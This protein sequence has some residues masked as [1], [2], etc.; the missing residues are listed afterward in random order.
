M[1]PNENRSLE[2]I[3]ESAIVVSWAD[4]MRGAQT[5]LIHIEYGF[6]TGGTLDYLKFWSSLTRG[7]WLLACEYWM[8]ASTFHCI[9]VHFDN[10]YQ[11]E[12]LAH[13]L[14]AV[15]QHQNAFTLPA[16]L[17]RQ[18]LLQIP[19]PTPE[20]RTAATASVNE[21]FDRLGPALAEPVLA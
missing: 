6:A 4:L 5:G 8:S 10:G 1:K 11:S 14:D 15:M 16:D 12:G 7:H 21:A 19:T 18:G 2:R 13:I 9:G 3:L 17:G 20:E